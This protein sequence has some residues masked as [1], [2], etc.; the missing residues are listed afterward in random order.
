SSGEKIYTARLAQ[1]LVAAGA[2]VTFMGPA[3]SAA[4]SLPAAEAFGSRIEWSIVPGRPNPTVLALA[5]P[6]PLVAARFATRDYAQHL[7]TMLGERD[8]DVVILSQYAMVWAIDH[9]HRSK[10]NDA[11]PIIG[12]IS[13]NFETKLA[14]D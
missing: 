13:H 2:S 5:S 11:R 3:T 8:F 4:S 14:A 9:I 1:A 10:K 6:L 7:E 12:Y